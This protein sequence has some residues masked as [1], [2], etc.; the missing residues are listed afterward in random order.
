ML[1]EPLSEP[2][3]DDDGGLSEFDEF[4]LSRSAAP[5]DKNPKSVAGSKDAGGWCCCCASAMMQTRRVEKERRKGKKSCLKREETDREYS[6]RA[7]TEM[8]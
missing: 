8:I 2:R 7:R 4:V 3:D 5:G 6:G 1:V